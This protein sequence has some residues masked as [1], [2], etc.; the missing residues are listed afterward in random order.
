MFLPREIIKNLHRKLVI[1][2]FGIIYLATLSPQNDPC[3]IILSYQILAFSIVVNSKCCENMKVPKFCAQKYS[4]CDS[5][6]W[7]IQERNNPIVKYCWRRLSQK[8]LL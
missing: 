2:D 4:Y 1:F 8:R 7:L 5:I 6:E 3:H